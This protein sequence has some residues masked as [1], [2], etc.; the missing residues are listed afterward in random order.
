MM[1]M[2]GVRS[3]RA[4]CLVLLL[5]NV[6]LAVTR[7]N[8]T[9][10]KRKHVLFV[11]VDPTVGKYNPCLHC[12]WWELRKVFLLFEGPVFR[13]LSLQ[14]STSKANSNPAW[15][16]SFEVCG[17][18]RDE[19]WKSSRR[20]NVHDTVLADHDLFLSCSALEGAETG[21]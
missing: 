10:K 9:R 12:E 16:D 19:Q 20:P 18:Q 11:K 5:P 4:N 17:E 13:G 2:T 7:N 14:K 6:R 8:C 1:M 15:L 3:L 21:S